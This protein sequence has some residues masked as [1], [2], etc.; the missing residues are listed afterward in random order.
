MAN[1]TATVVQNVLVPQNQSLWTCQPPEIAHDLFNENEKGIIT[2]GYILLFIFS[3]FGNALIIAVF[4]RK[5]DQLQTPVNYF[6]VN[7]AASDLLI[8]LVVLPRRVQETYIGWTPWLVEGVVGDILCRVVHYVDEVSVTVSSQ[9]MIFIAVERWWSVVF[10]L[11][12]P[13][14]TKQTTPKFICFTWAL[15]LLF[16]SYC[17]FAYKTVTVQNKTLCIIDFPEIFDD[18]SDF[19]K[20]DRVNLLVTFVIVPFAIMSVLYSSIIFSIHRNKQTALHLSSTEQVKRAKENRRVAVMLV[21]VVALFFISWTPY[22][23]YY[24]VRYLSLSTNWSCQS[25]SRLYFCSKF[26]NYIYT[27]INPLIYYYFSTNYRQGLHELLC[28]PWSCVR[29]CKHRV[30]VVPSSVQPTVQSIETKL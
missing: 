29:G 4:R 12:S 25:K 2:I 11:K 13:L 5:Y 23:I 28:C 14:I 10:P 21:I 15:S 9:S 3:L 18:W 17:F 27:G 1:D 19:W 22:Y 6:I 16:F 7:M 20:A 26:M 30:Q 24:F 8:P